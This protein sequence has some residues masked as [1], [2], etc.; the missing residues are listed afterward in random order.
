MYQDE[1]KQ[2]QVTQAQSGNT[3]TI[4]I[5]VV[6]VDICL[7]ICTILIFLIMLLFFKGF[8]GMYAFTVTQG[9]ELSTIL[10]RALHSNVY[11]STVGLSSEQLTFAG[12]VLQR[13]SAD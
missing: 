13:C 6:L 11:S 1:G 9:N 12:W 7:K 2:Y 10:P 5:C 4:A 8:L 3:S